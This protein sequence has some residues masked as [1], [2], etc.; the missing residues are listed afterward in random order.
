MTTL[1]DYQAHST[2]WREQLQ[3]NNRRTHWVIGIFF[4][5]YLVLGIILDLTFYSTVLHSP[6]DVL[7]KQLFTLKL[8][9]FATIITVI[10]AAIS[11]AVT[12]IFH[13]KLML[14]GTEYHEVTSDSARS[15]EEKQLYNV[16]EEMKVAAGLRFM[17]RVYIIEANYMNAFASGYSEKSAM[18]AITRGLM[19][20][21]DRAEMQ[22]VMAHE[23]SHIRHQ[24]IKLTLMA[25]VLTNIMLVVIDLLFYNVVF[26]RR[27]REGGNN[28]L[29]LVVILLRYI[30]PVVTLLLMLYLSRTREYMADAGCVE[31][32]RDNSPLARAL[33]KIHQD[34]Q[35]NVAE[36]SQEYGQTSHEDIRRAAYIY[37]PVKTGIE[38]VKSLTS[39][40]STHPALEARLAAIGFKPAPKR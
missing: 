25:S 33:L 17:P 35:T 6:L 22:A 30:L 38:P 15:L 14:L 21:L 34:H 16:V 20:K 5:L 9:P 37:D 11:L 18:V 2:D 31:L 29:V 19:N 36:Y 28:I 12:Y 27:D 26:G 23:L 39:M 8:I 7:I 32:M 3:K 4:M 40:F 24:D 13:D 1:S 10:I